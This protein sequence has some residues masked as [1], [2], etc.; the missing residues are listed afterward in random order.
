MTLQKQEEQK[1]SSC[2][3]Y[4]GVCQNSKEKPGF[5]PGRHWGKEVYIRQA[6]RYN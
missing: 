1:C 3:Y 6:G 2:F 4:G 5:V